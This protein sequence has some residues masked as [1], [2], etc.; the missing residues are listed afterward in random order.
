MRNLG[1]LFLA[2]ILALG[3]ANA[4]E[5]TLKASKINGVDVYLLPE[6]GEANED[7]VID[8]FWFIEKVKANKIPKGIHLVDV[9]KA[10]KFKAEHIKGAISVPFDSDK[11]TLDVSKLPKDGIIVF[12]CNTGTK[13]TDARGSLEDE[14]ASRVFVFDAT[15]KCD[16]KYKNCKLS[17]NEAL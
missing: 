16:K 5:P 1:K 8:Q 3:L 4:Y 6:D 9:R 15:Y 2:S 17:A 12:Y 7:G 10:E 14:L 11:E 13:S